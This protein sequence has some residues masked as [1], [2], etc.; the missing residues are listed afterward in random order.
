MFNIISLLAFNRTSY[1]IIEEE[2]AREQISNGI[3]A[4]RFKKYAGE[5]LYKS[6]Q[7]IMKYVGESL[8][9]SI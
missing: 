8:H 6:I 3:Y 5:S 7:L 1:Y 2:K 9:K 4:I